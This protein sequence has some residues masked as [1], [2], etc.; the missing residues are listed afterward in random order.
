M[1]E[2]EIKD[3]F[4]NVYD[5]RKGRHDEGRL[6]GLKDV[7]TE[8]AAK[9]VNV[10][11][12]V[13][14][15]YRTLFDEFLVRTGDKDV[16][17]VFNLRARSA[18]SKVRGVPEDTFASGDY[19]VPE[20]T[21]VR[22]TCGERFGA[23]SKGLAGEGDGTVRPGKVV[24]VLAARPQGNTRLVVEI[25][26]CRVGGEFDERPSRFRVIKFWKSRGARGPV[27]GMFR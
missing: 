14:T 6:C 16:F 7:I 21:D 2:G 25:T 18:E 19:P 23:E 12:T 13:L 20:E 15:K 22:G 1:C 11:V 24:K 27:K 3:A 9:A 5:V 4:K 26:S 10:G 8:C 17:K